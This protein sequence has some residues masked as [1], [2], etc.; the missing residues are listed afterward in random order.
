MLVLI[1]KGFS[2]GNSLLLVKAFTTY[3][4]PLLEYN[5]Y[6]WWPNDVHNITKNERVQRRFKKRIPSVSHLSYSEIHQ[7]LG[8]EHSNTDVLLLI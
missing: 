4:R 8:L 6:I 5:T 3:V 1:Y 2:S 7:F